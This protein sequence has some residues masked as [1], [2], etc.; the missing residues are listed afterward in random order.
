[1][2]FRTPEKA[3]F[4]P[5][6][7]QF[8]LAPKCIQKPL[9]NARRM[10]VF[11]MDSMFSSAVCPRFV[12]VSGYIFVPARNEVYALGEHTFLG[13]KDRIQK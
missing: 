12:V 11:R 6:I 9:Q 2:R 10:H 7:L 13:V 1:M 5:D 4:P 8:A 3:C